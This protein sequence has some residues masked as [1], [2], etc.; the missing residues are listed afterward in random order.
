M[1]T[2]LVCD[3][4]G[5]QSLDYQGLHIA[6]AWFTV[7]DSA[8]RWPREWLVCPTC[9]AKALPQ[10]VVKGAEGGQRASDE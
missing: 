9:I 8:Q 6:N 5:Q 2:I 3:G 10:V 4:C 1:A 7:K